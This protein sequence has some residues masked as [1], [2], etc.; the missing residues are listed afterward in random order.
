MSEF[1]SAGG[2]KVVVN[3]GGFKQAMALKSAILKEVSKA[4][5]DLSFGDMRVEDFDVSA[6]AKLAAAVD[7]SPE[8][9]A[10][11]FDCLSRCTY[12]GHKIT[13]V[14]F[15]KVEARAD[16]YEIVI[17]CLKENLLPFF[18]GLLSKLAPFLQGLQEAQAGSTPKSA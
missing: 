15:E 5:F 8:V 16:Y 4:D 11:L 13:E 12:G 7:S 18:G 1:M 2:V 17:A 3:P 14:T 9:Y 6:L 10:C